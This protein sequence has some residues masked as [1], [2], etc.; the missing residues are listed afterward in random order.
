MNRRFIILIFTLTSI[1]SHSQ[2]FSNLLPPPPKTAKENTQMLLIGFLIQTT[3]IAMTAAS[4]YVYLEGDEYQSEIAD[5][6]IVTGVGLT[7]T[8][9]ALIIASIHNMMIVRRSIRELKK[10]KKNNSLSFHL[11]PTNY[12]LGLVCKF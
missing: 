2:D 6:G 3:G 11:E 8:G 5:A 9:S 7:T 4:V 12:G 1:L 10:K